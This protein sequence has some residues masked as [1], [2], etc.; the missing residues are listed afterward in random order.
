MVR[1]VNLLM[2]DEGADTAV[3]E[4]DVPTD[5]S[6]LPEV[7]A[8]GQSGFV[9]ASGEQVAEETAAEEEDPA[10]VEKS[11]ATAPVT[12]AEPVSHHDNL[13]LSKL[14]PEEDEDEMLLE[15]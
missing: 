10:E 6:E 13:P 8:F 11:S 3:E 1:L 15:V 2:R 5:A 4:V 14:Q 7:P 12:E 9:S